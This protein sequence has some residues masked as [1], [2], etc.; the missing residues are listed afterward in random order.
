MKSDLFANVS[1]VQNSS[2]IL[3][4][5]IWKLLNCFSCNGPVFTIKI[6]VL[7]M[8]PN[9]FELKSDLIRIYCICIYL[10]LLDL[11]FN[12]II[13]IFITFFI[14]LCGIA[15]LLCF[16]LQ[17]KNLVFFSSKQL[18]TS[19]QVLIFTPIF[20]NIYYVDWAVNISCCHDQHSLNLEKWLLFL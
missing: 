12:I 1:C 11:D 19:S 13:F 8:L 4:T 5:L 6:N 2:F 10:I 17:T 16:S 7:K 14:T 18:F 9:V 15:S 20:W 3:H